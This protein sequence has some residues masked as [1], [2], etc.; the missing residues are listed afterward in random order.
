MSV[1]HASEI[2]HFFEEDKEDIFIG[3]YYF[4]HTG[5]CSLH[6]TCPTQWEQWAGVK[7]PGEAG[8]LYLQSGEASR[9]FGC[10]I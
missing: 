6:L 4:T 10:Q 8:V 7:A 2:Q 3:K 1:D 9:I 5:I